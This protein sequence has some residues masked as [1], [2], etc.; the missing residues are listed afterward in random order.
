[1]QNTDLNLVMQNFVKNSEISVM[2]NS[3][4]SEQR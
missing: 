2:I 4:S 3:Y 1:V